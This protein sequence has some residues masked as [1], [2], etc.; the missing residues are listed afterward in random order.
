MP[1]VLSTAPEGL[2]MNMSSRYGLA[3]TIPLSSSSLWSTFT[4]PTTLSDTH[5]F[6]Q[7]THHNPLTRH[8]S[9]ISIH[10][11]MKHDLFITNHSSTPIYL[12]T[13]IH[14]F[15]TIHFVT[16][17]IKQLARKQVWTWL[18]ARSVEAQEPSTRVFRE[19]GFKENSRRYLRG[20]GAGALS[21]LWCEE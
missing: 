20:A 16:Q 10:L 3:G 5:F 21:Q 1:L 4:P 8:R 2:V 19:Q 17:P 12:F 13:N 11:H 7:V 6:I 18:D 15:I 14:L 9:L